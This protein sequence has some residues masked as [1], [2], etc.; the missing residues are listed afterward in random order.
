MRWFG[1]VVWVLAVNA[2]AAGQGYAEPGRR[3]PLDLSEKGRTIPEGTPTAFSRS[4]A[5]RFSDG[6]PTAD[7][8]AD[9]RAQNFVCDQDAT[10]CTHALMIGNCAT[11]W[12]VDFNEDGTLS[13]RQAFNCMG[14][15]EDD[16]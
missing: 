5:A 2:C 7:I 9:L 14:A 13:T 3:P 15:L 1:A 12:T 4:V 16:E 11:S 10:Y 8:L 6:L